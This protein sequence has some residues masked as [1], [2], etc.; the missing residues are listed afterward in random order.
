MSDKDCDA[1]F[2]LTK[3]YKK[4]MEHIR[5]M[6]DFIKNN[7]ADVWADWCEWKRIDAF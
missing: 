1:R 2:K 3:E 4:L 5:L 7:C 6:K